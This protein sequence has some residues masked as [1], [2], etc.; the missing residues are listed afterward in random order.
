MANF[1]DYNQIIDDVVAMIRAKVPSFKLVDRN[2]DPQQFHYANFPLCD[3]RI[4]KGSPTVT[5]GQVYYVPVTVEMEIAASD[6]SSVDKGATIALDLLNKTQRAFVE[7][8]HWGAVWDAMILGQFRV[9]TA[10]DRSANSGGA[11][12]T[13]ILAE[14]MI[15]VYSQ[16]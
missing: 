13:S 8:S 6:L 14:V 9:I 16:P 1:V 2:V 3:V 4:T 10:Q 11:F 7:N 12:V 15:N 5:A